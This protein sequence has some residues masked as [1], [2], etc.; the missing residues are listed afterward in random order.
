MNI[1]FSDLGI[2][3]LTILRF[4][5][6]IVEYLY[7]QA[8]G[9]ALQLKV[10][11]SAAAGVFFLLFCWHLWFELLFTAV[12]G[13]FVTRIEERT[14]VPFLFA[15][16]L[17]TVILVVVEYKL[18]VYRRTHLGEMTVKEVAD[19]LPVG[20][21]CYDKDG[22]IYLLNEEMVDLSMRISGMIPS[23]GEVLWEE[24]SRCIMNVEEGGE[25]IPVLHF[26][27]G[28][29]Y[30]FRKQEIAV[31]NRS[32]TEITAV[33]VTELYDA[34]ERLK[35][36]NIKQEEINRRLKQYGQD[37]ADMIRAREILEAKMSMHDEVGQVLLATR[38]AADHPGEIETR[39]ILEMWKHLTDVLLKE[40]EVDEDAASDVFENLIDVAKSIGI[41]VE[42]EGEIPKLEPAYTL[43]ARG[44]HTCITNVR[45]HTDGDRIF[46]SI[47]KADGGVMVSFTNNGTPPADIIQETG[48][49][50]S[51]RELVES[52]GGKM[53]IES[54]PFFRLKLFL[55]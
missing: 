15:A 38:Y 53:E 18:V 4:A 14:V 20:M 49:L 3:F 44:L 25:G 10:K 13:S 9:R 22:R 45:K 35:Q 46:L 31:E 19:V 26:D 34:S 37:M 11:R 51:L 17:L 12:P 27:N 28:R 39:G 52:A 30:Q 2:P 29:V 47:T 21:C 55:R 42:I 6:L 32:V 54:R 16:L 41:K 40:A 1:V 50:L 23:D 7:L 33:N 24:I 5:S 36:Q 43:T 48:G 8:V